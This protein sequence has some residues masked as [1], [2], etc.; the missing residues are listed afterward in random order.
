MSA[1]PK[2]ALECARNV[3]NV[4]SI[5]SA[6]FSMRI[7][8]VFHY[9]LAYRIPRCGNKKLQEK[10]CYPSTARG[11]GPVTFNRFF[12]CLLFV[13]LCICSHVW[14]YISETSG[15]I[16]LKF[17]MP[18]GIEVPS[19]VLKYQI[20]ESII[21]QAKVV[22]SET[23]GANMLKSWLTLQSLLW[24][25]VLKFHNKGINRNWENLNNCAV[26]KWTC[27]NHWKN[28][29]QSTQKVKKEKLL[30]EATFMTLQ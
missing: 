13:C 14:P 30:W 29:F 16:S 23:T 6:S 7:Q 1:C 19:I 3:K 18:C 4:F 22:I 15:P 21:K 5:R 8:N 20:R 10:E 26:A 27:S 2:T 11:G 17:W 28:N 24:C 12:V 25:V 9:I